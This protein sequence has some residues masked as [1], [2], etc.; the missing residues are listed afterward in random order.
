MT[1]RHPIIPASYVVL[2]KDGKILLARRY[3][4]GYEDGKYSLPA[5]HVEEGETFT[6]AL[7]REIKEEINIDID[8]CDVQGM[9]VM[10]RDSHY[11]CIELRYRMDI[12]FLVEKWCGELENMEPEKCDDL[13]W[14]TLDALPKNT[15]P[16]IKKALKD[17][18]AGVAYS[19][20]GYK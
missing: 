1:Q 16:Y 11:E 19:E 13:L 20:Y 14:C 9:H 8:L 10:Q 15:I 17:I 5:G 12:F 3:Q 18:D 4:T 6:G 7:V 2:R